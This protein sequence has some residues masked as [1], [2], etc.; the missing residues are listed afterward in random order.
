MRSAPERRARRPALIE[1]LAAPVG[2]EIGARVRLRPI[3]PFRFC[4]YR[5]WEVHGVNRSR[6][7]GGFKEGSD[8]QS[9]KQTPNNKRLS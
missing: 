7:G 5:G 8:D 9:F 3:G 6:A 1:V 4:M 2:G